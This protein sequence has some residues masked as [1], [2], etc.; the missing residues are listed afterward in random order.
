MDD[1]SM[2][3]DLLSHESDVESDWEIEESTGDLS[4]SDTE[5]ATGILTPSERSSDSEW[6]IDESIS[7]LNVS[8]TEEATEILTPSEGSSDSEWM[9]TPALS[10]ESGE[11]DVE[12]GGEI[13]ESVG[14]MHALDEYNSI[15]TEEKTGNLTASDKFSE[16]VSIESSNE[17]SESDG[18]AGEQIDETDSEQY[19]A[20]LPLPEKPHDNPSLGLLGRLPRKI[21]DTIYD[22]CHQDK[23][24]SINL[25]RRKNPGTLH[26]TISALLP[27][28]RLTSRTVMFEYNLRCPAKAV[29]IRGGLMRRHYLFNF[30]Q[31]PYVAKGAT[32]RRG[33]TY[34]SEHKLHNL[35]TDRKV[36]LFE[37]AGIATNDFTTND[38][39]EHTAWLKNC[40]IVKLSDYKLFKASLRFFDDLDANRTDFLRVF[41][42]FQISFTREYDE[43]PEGYEKCPVDHLDCKIFEVTLHSGEHELNQQCENVPTIGKWTPQDGFKFNGTPHGLFDPRTGDLKVVK[44]LKK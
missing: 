6:E 2:P 43:C 39:T 20:S 44:S 21:R 16:A 42:N 22:L 7:D 36:L 31:S 26:F 13:D 17:S 12:A 9:E 35:Q 28:M 32:D 15:V 38:Y 30:A 4:V 29:M 19:L 23:R 41:G 10:D 33:E 40:H 37:V 1:N 34:L 5:E 8:D 3:I 24:Y 14:D 18:E 27:Q 25:R 11:S